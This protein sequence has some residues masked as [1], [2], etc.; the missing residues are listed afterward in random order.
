VP[1]C[2]GTGDVTARVVY[3]ADM[4][5]TTVRLSEETKDRL[6]ALG[7]KGDT[8]EVIVKRLLDVVAILKLGSKEAS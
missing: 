2:D 6:L 8:Y 1:P 3:N 5:F 4:K 7:D